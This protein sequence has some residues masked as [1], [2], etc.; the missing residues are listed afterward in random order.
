MISTM[1]EI[2]SHI[3]PDVHAEPYRGPIKVGDKIGRL[4]VVRPTGKRF[5]RV[6]KVTGKR[7]GSCPI[8]EC[9]CDCGNVREF[10]TNILMRGR[11]M[12]TRISCGCWQKEIVRQTCADVH[13]RRRLPEGEGALNHVISRYKHGAKKRGLTFELTKEQFRSLVLKNCFYCGAPPTNRILEYIN[14]NRLENGKYVRQPYR[15]RNGGLVYSG[16]DRKDNSVGYIEPNC[17]PCCIDCNIAKSNRTVEGFL[18]WIDRVHNYQ[19][20]TNLHKS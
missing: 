2:V 12:K 3:E 10:N 16:V 4:T 14:G 15:R 1:P 6:Y 17:V 7:N 8:F 11:S 20:A 18:L 13:E 9:R 19:N 5:V